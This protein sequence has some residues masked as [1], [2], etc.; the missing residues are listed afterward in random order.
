MVRGGPPRS[1]GRPWC[2]SRRRTGRACRSP[3]ARAAPR[4]PRRVGASG[5]SRAP[6]P[7]C[8]AQLDA[9][10]G[11]EPRLRAA[12]GSQ[13][14]RGAGAAL[15]EDEQV[16][17]REGGR[18]HLGEISAN[19]S[20]AWPGPPASATT[21]AA[22]SGS[23]PPRRGRRASA[24]CRGTAPRAV[25]RDVDVGA[26]V[27]RGRAGRQGIVGPRRRRR[28]SDGEPASAISASAARGRDAAGEHV[29]RTVASAAGKRRRRT[30]PHVRTIA[31]PSRAETP[32]R[33]SVPTAT[34]CGRAGCCSC[35]GQTP[36][37]PATGELVEGDIG[38]QTRRCLGNLEAVCAAAGAS[39]GDAVR[40][41]IY[42]TDMA[43][44]GEVNEA[45]AEFFPTTR[46]RARR[47]AWR[48]C[49]SAPRSR[50]TRS[51]R[52]RTERPPRCATEPRH[53]RGRRA[54]ARG[55]R[56]R[57]APDA[58]PALGDAQRALR[59]RRACSR[60]RACSAP[61]RS[62]SAAR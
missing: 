7:S 8:A 59:R 54:R 52:W 9:S 2:R 3:P 41:G 22:R 23:T 43:T 55:D 57:R 24:T 16:A 50:S 60:P 11:D 58:G 28:H 36:L 61:A 34:R 20:A 35:S 25:E 46:P 12:P 10:V 5:R 45:Y 27:A 49:R 47:S 29:A 56:R 6:A 37:D 26:L 62:R 14:A 1:P 13:R 31:S 33:P 44:F 53:R 15:V 17:G 39:L 51:S 32:P 42:V 18:E 30:R 38:E 19:G 48:R 4:C 21:A 40:C